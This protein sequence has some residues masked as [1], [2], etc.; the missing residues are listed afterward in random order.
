[1]PDHGKSFSPSS[2]APDGELERVL[3]DHESEPAVCETEVDAT[4]IGLAKGRR[5]PVDQVGQDL[6]A[7]TRL[8]EK[9][10][11]RRLHDL[12]QWGV[13][14]RQR[15]PVSKSRGPRGWTWSLGGDAWSRFESVADAFTL[16]QL[17]NEIERMRKGIKERSRRSIRPADDAGPSQA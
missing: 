17:E 8:N 5:R 2:R 11:E 9:T 13:A 1:M 4:G 16:K 6:V 7:E 12:E 15:G 14:R 10:I 3:R